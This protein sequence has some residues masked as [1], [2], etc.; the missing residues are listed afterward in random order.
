MRSDTQKRINIY[1]TKLPRIKEKI[2]ASGLALLIAGI[3]AVSATFAWVTLSRAPEVSGLATSMSAN[4]SLEIALSKEDGSQ[5]DEFDVDESVGVNDDVY[6]TNLTWG[7]LVN[8]SDARYGIDNLALRPAQLNSSAL[9]TNPLWGAEYSS[10]GRIVQLNSNFAYARYDGVGSFLTSNN[11]YGVRAIASYVA[12]VSDATQQEQREKIQDIVNAHTAVNQTYSQVADKFSALG[13]MI[14]KYAQD[15]LNEATPG[16]NLAPYLSDVISCYEAVKDAMEAQKGAYVA[17]ANFQLYMQAQNAGTAYT[18]T[19][20]DTIYANR[21]AYNAADAAANSSN[22]II[23][24]AGLTQFITDYNNL[25]AD[26]GYLNQYYDDYRNNATPYYWSSGATGTPQIST[27]IAR[28]ID[29]NTMTIDLDDD[30]KEVVVTQLSTNNAGSLLGANGKSRK[31]YTYKGI[32]IRFEQLAVDEAN[33]LNGR[34][35]CQIKVTYIMT[36]TVNGKAYTKA[37]GPATFTTAYNNAVGSATL[38]AND[39]VAD[40]TYGMAVDFWVRTNAEETCLT[41]EG[42]TAMDEQGNIVSYDGVNRVWGRSE[43]AQTLP[44]GST[45]QGGGSCYVYYADTPEDMAR[46]LDLL[47]AMKVAFVDESGTLLA[48]AEMDTANVFASNGRITVP[49]VLTSDTRTTY[50]YTNEQNEQQIGRA[51]TTLYTDIPIRIEAIIYLDGTMLGNDNVLSAATIQGQLNIQYGSSVALKTIGNSDLMDD[52]RLVSA[53]LTKSELDYDNAITDDDLTTGVVVHVD[54]VDPTSMT[55]FFVRA[56]NSQQGSREATFALTKQQN[57]DWTADYKFAAPGDYYLRYIRLGGVDYPLLEPQK[58]TVK[59]FAVNSVTWGESSDSVIVRT[60]ADSYTESVSV[61]FAT[62]DRSKMPSTVSAQFVRRDGNIVSVPLS[63]TPSGKWTGKGTLVASNEYTLRYLIYGVGGKNYRRDLQPQGLTKTIDL[64]LGLRVEVLNGSGAEREEYTAGS[65]YEKDLMVHIQDNAGNEIEG[66]SDAILYYSNGGSATNTIN[67]NLTWDEAEGCY[68]GVLP[69]TRPGRYVFS[70][71]TVAGDILTRCTA[72]PVY[73]I[74]SPDPPTYRTTSLATF[75]GSNI[76]FAPLTNDAYIDGLVIDYAES[77]VVDAIVYNASAVVEGKQ[78]GYYM[79]RMENGDVYNAGETWVIRLPSYTTD[80]DAEGSPNPNAVYTQEGTWQLV[81]LTVHDCYDT[82]ASLRDES[83]PI[84]W[85][86]RSSAWST[87]LSAREITPD[88]RYDFS[89]LSTT[90]SC[91]YHVEMLPGAT[92]LGSVSAPFMSHYAVSDIGMKVRLTD[93]SGRV[94]PANKVGDT[95]LTVNYA[96]DTANGTYGYKVQS[97]AARAYT[98]SLNAQD[99]D[100]GY[101]TVS[102]VN[103]SPDGDWQYVGEYNVQNLSVRLGNNTFRYGVGENGVPAQYTITTAGPS[104]DNVTLPDENITQRY[105]TLGKVLN[106]VTGTFLQAQNPG[107]TAKVTLA[108]EDGSDTQYVILD[109]VTMQL[110]MTYQDGKTAPNGGYSWAG[111]SQYETVT[112]D[113]TNNSGTYRTSA[114]P[115]LAGTYA[116]QL[117]CSVNGANT[118]KDLSDVSVYS[119]KPTLKVTGVSPA[120]GETIKVSTINDTSIMYE[121]LEND[122]REVEERFGVIEVSNYYSEL[123]GSAANVFISIDDPYSKVLEDSKT[124]YTVKHKLP[125]VSFELSQCGTAFNSCRVVIPNQALPAQPSTVEFGSASQEDGIARASATIGYIEKKH[126]LASEAAGCIGSNEYL[127]YDV[128]Y[129]VGKQ[130]ISS[131]SLYDK[132]GLAY[133]V[134]LSNT[135]TI[136]ESSDVPPGVQFVNLTGYT[137][138]N[139]VTSPTSGEFLYTLPDAESFGVLTAEEVEISDDAEWVE[140]NRS[141]T[142]YYYYA[143]LYTGKQ[144]NKQYNTTKYKNDKK[145][146]SCYEGSTKSG[147]DTNYWYQ[148]GFIYHVYQRVQRIEESTSVTKTYSVTRGLVGWEIDGVQYDPGSQIT[149]TKNCT[150]IPVIGIK[151][152]TFITESVQTLSKTYEIDEIYENKTVFDTVETN[153]DSTT[154][155]ARVTNLVPKYG[156]TPA[157]QFISDPFS[158]IDSTT[159]KDAIIYDWTEKK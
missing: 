152:K 17:L 90:V 49:L 117:K 137:Q 9:L 130:T 85:A 58:I 5:P 3:V 43:E 48:T 87:Y 155:K 96:P 106:T 136:R 4:G 56:I 157:T 59:G 159:G 34:A 153:K 75:N 50:T 133:E 125:S 31:V 57:G 15:K 30:G 63:Y 65:S 123:D 53:Y 121:K 2:G 54:G 134:I 94:I 72:S 102:A 12:T 116:V 71:V 70:S 69:I 27:I 78:S 113:M 108:T 51:I 67:T 52:V 131:V 84:I 141:T 95:T 103:G 14:S 139:E 86:D 150:A 44:I 140:T 91:T 122:E 142:G 39:S 22:G 35:A 88:A 158:H 109:G 111:T 89:R 76:Q 55:A 24:L 8:L 151:D 138:F 6:V 64:S 97:G 156:N 107:V 33:R 149:V 99:P 42:A 66:L 13:T 110:I 127:D 10:D 36:I 74:I 7:N 147:C 92:A 129:D 146:I 73:R 114:T 81:M 38:A 32:L 104:A 11:T 105:T 61:E 83:N 28:L 79:L 120:M 132:A 148:C 1:K 118:I 21:T 126:D 98:I 29:Y 23:K 19:S 26:I 128:K 20:W 18:P 40:D 144:G 80:L 16:T 46:S 45:T 101:R 112:I 115:L 47:D 37:S 93:D 145:G 119:L 62:N 41:L 124:H 135:V 25:V 154:A 143:D 100:T 82:N 77:A 60:S 68:R